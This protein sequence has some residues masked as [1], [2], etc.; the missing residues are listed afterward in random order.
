MRKLAAVLLMA[1][2]LAFAAGDEDKPPKNPTVFCT[3]GKVYD[4]E[5]GKCV[6]PKE[7]SLDRDEL[8]QAVRQFAY[9][10]A[11]EDAQSVAQ[12]LPADDPGRLTYM[13]FTHRKLGNPELAMIYYQR[14]IDMDP[15]NILARS[16]M[17]QGHVEAGEI[18]LAMVQL[19]AIRDHGG[20]GTWSEASLRNAIATGTTYNY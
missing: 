19:K 8:Y 20:G 6:A 18:D 13:G 17:G 16:Y 1:P 11:F 2:T 4:K 9:A 12:A 5:V 10:G 14:A 3:G 15:A 7:S